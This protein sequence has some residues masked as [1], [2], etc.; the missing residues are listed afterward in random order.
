MGYMAFNQQHETWQALFLNLASEF[1]GV[2]LIFLLVNVLFFIDDWDLSEKVSQLIYKLSNPSASDFFRNPPD[3][4]ELQQYIQFAKRVDLLGVTLTVTLNRNFSAL[5][6]KLLD[7]TDIR[8]I[9]IYPNVQTLKA[10]AE[11]SESGSVDYY[12]RRLEASLND[13]EYLYTNWQ[14][15]KRTTPEKIGTLEVRLLP[16]TP[17]FGILNFTSANNDAIAIVEMYPHHK[18]YDLPPNFYL[19]KEK[20]PDWYNYFTIQ[21]EEMWKR[22]SPWQPGMTVVMD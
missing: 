7:G 19:S 12:R 18:G 5:R 9:I 11:R 13:I 2:V 1:F 20:D 10:A 6:H 4:A 15:Y 22:T 8:I 17:S 14:D 3:V 16:Y 21:F